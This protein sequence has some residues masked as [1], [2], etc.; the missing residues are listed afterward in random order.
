MLL[1]K[2]PAGRAA[3]FTAVLAGTLVLG[4]CAGNTPYGEMQHMTPTG[5]A[6]SK[7]LYQDYAALARS[8]GMADAPATSAFDASGSISISDVQPDVA[9]VGNAYAAKAIIAAK[10]EEPLPEPAPT[11]DIGA[12]DL[13]MKLLRA[14]DHGRAKA[15]EL[16]ARTQADYDCWVVNSTVDALARSAGACK[17]AF[18]TELTRLEQTPGVAL[19]PA[20]AP[21]APVETQPEPPAPT[22]S[23]NPDE[24][25]Q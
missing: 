20:A 7:A 25:V 14:L 19:A 21:T 10:G 24:D 8:L 16:A 2:R 9:A 13:R 4:G 1:P 12:E 23:T 5:S 15:P 6:F 11:D 22:E 17:S 18:S 3:A